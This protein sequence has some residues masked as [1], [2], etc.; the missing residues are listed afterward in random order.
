MMLIRRLCFACLVAATS[1]AQ[2][3]TIFADNFDQ[4]NLGMNKTQFLA[5]WDVASGA[6]DLIG[7]G[8]AWNLMPAGGRYVD[9]DGSLF[10]GGTFT[11]S[12]DLLAGV[13]YSASFYLAGNHRRAGTDQVDVS[14]GSS[15]RS[16][17]V[18]QDDLFSL[19]SL[20]FTPDKNGSYVLGFHNQGSDNMGVLLDDVSVDTLAQRLIAQD[21]REIPE[22][23]TGFLVLTGFALAAGLG[24]RQS[25]AAARA[26]AQGRS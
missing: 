16:F 3:G 23:S 11:H 24:R 21:V 12:F 19:A 17:T 4:E 22:P 8:G 13:T 9:L 6:V 5:G 15:L 26:K 18:G 10:K 14:F 20:L 2:A 25:E 1:A 7:I